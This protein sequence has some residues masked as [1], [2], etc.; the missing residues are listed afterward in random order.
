VKRKKLFVASS[1]AQKRLVDAFQTELDKK[2]KLWSVPLEV[3]LWFREDVAVPG[4]DILT[5]LTDQCRGR[6]EP[7]VSASDFFAAFLTDD[8]RLER[9]G[10]EKAGTVGGVPRDNCI[11]ELGLFTGGLGFDLE[12]CFMLCSVPRASLPSD[13]DGRTY[14]PFELPPVD[15]KQEDYDSAVHPVADAVLRSILRLK[16]YH[17]AGLERI[18]TS[19]LMERER[20][21]DKNG[22]LDDDA[23]VVVNRAQP[24]EERRED[25]AALVR[26]NIRAGITYRYFFHELREKEFANTFNSIARLVYRVAAANPDKDG[27]PGKPPSRDDLEQSLNEAVLRSFCINLLPNQGPIECCVHNARSYNGSKCYVKYPYQD[28]FVNFC[29]DAEALHVATKLKDLEVE[30]NSPRIFRPTQTFDITHEV[31][32]EKKTALLDSMK[33]E[34]REYWDADLEATLKKVCF[35]ED[36]R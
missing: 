24:F 13:L 11:F 23:E 3:K 7:S 16:P 29:Q 14:I 9:G 32:K 5:A 31:H 4:G 15:G 20:P 22:D 25:F 18:T 8:D 35:G 28:Y 1:S 36:P 27:K 12:R 19:D 21:S 34:F 6:R 26:S 33:R 17:A 30:C 2:A 10:G